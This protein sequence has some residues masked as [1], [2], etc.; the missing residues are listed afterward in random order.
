MVLQ[1][2]VMKMN[3]ENTDDFP[4]IICHFSFFIGFGRRA[5]LVKE[6]LSADYADYAER[7][8]EVRDQRSDHKKSALLGHK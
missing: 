5:S 2:K 4:Y 6:G 8:A 3:P 7:K 1:R